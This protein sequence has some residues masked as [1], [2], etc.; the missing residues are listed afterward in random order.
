M[1]TQNG[2]NGFDPFELDS[3]QKTDRPRGRGVAWLA[4]LVALA[5]TGASGYLWW[6]DWQ[7]GMS[8]ADRQVVLEEIRRGQSATGQRLE[9]LEN[10]MLTAEQG[11]AEAA[12]DAL[13]RSSGEFA[14]RLEG[15]ENDAV[16]GLARDQSLQAALFDLQQTTEGL[17]ATV[18]ALTA[19]SDGPGQRLDMYEV[20]SLLR[21]ASERLQLFGDVS[22]ADAALALADQRLAAMEDPVYV[23]VRQRIGRA[24]QALSAVSLPDLVQL[25]GRLSALQERVP[26]LP[27]PGENRVEQ[28]AENPVEQGMWARFKKTLSGLVTVR[29]TTAADEDMLSIGDKDYLRQGIWLQLETARLSMMRRDEQVYDQTLERAGATLQRYFDTDAESVQSALAE[30]RQLREIEMTVAMPDVSAPWSQLRL[31]RQRGAEAGPVPDREAAENGVLVPEPQ[32]SGGDE[33]E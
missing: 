17:A 8:E 32:A 14:T 29:R 6:L 22:A 20:E 23:T 13:R 10:R 12:I 24:R 1:N 28:A 27:F 15:V 31:L 11:S 9:S 26:R 33:G 19:R 4:L 30:I 21:M 2:D 18:G 3:D 7:A 5:A 25:E 16:E